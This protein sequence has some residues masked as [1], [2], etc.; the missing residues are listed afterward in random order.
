MAKTQAV[1]VKE[2]LDIA[3]SILGTDAPHVSKSQKEMARSKLEEMMKQETR[4]VKGRFQCFETPGA[5]VKVT[6]K[7]YKE[8]PIFEKEMTDGYQYEIPLYVARH[9]NGFDMTAGAA[10]DAAEGKFGNTD[11]GTCSYA[12]HGFIMPGKD[13][14]LN[15]SMNGDAGIPVPIVGVSRRVRRYGFQSLDFGSEG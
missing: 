13:A 11:I 10:A 9:L 15:P 12:K 1:A 7:K 8:V 4:L 2:K 6:V 5:T 14:A 3:S